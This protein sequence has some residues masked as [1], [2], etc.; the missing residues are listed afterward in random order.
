MMQRY[1]KLPFLY[2]SIVQEASVSRLKQM[3]E[4]SNLIDWGGR[5]LPLAKLFPP[6]FEKQM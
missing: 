1:S 6:N 5:V 3:I 2:S 4:S